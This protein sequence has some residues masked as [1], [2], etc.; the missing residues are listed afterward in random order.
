MLIKNVKIP[1]KTVV[2]IGILPS[3]LKKLLYRI[4]GY[5][6]G[7]NVSIGP[8]SVIIGKKVTIGD[9]VKI[10]LVTIIR[11]EEIIIE[12]FVTIGSFTVIDS[13]KLFIGEDSRINEQVI[14]GGM[15]TPASG[16]KLGK[17]TIIM[18][19]SF[20]NTTLPI[21]IGNDTGIGGHCLLFTHGSWLNQLDGFPVTFAPIKLG[22]NVWLPWRVFIMPGV[23]VGDNVVI[24]ANSL[25]TK[26][27]PS[28]VLAAGS[29]AKIIKENYPEKPDDSVRYDIITNIINEFIAYLNHHQNKT[30]IKTQEGNITLEISKGNRSYWIYYL[31]KNLKNFTIP[32]KEH[33]LILDYESPGE[34]FKDVSMIIDLRRKTRYGKTEIGEEFVKYVSRFGLRFNRLD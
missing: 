14:I 18:E 32:G 27:L 16:L 22:N 10:G 5:K 11:G 12:R 23:E 9:N 24:G 33:L 28:N 29:P 8:G 21:E 2:T 17:R 6:I 1:F 19:Y 15:K 13:G 3:F 30:L 25:I 4:R 26:N 7:K 20:I 31:S 34:E